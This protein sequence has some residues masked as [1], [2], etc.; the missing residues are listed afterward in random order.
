MFIKYLAKF[1]LKIKF[2]G[3]INDPLP[4]L[5]DNEQDL[6]HENIVKTYLF[7]QVCM[8][9]SALETSFPV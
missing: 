9:L 2:Q 5:S 6:S 1:C 7:H 4:V 3:T 8:T